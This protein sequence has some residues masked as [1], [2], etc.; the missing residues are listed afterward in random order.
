M[1]KR[2]PITDHKSRFSW[3]RLWLF[4]LDDTLHH[5][6][7]HIF[8]RQY[9]A[10]HRFIEQRFALTRDEA[11]VRRREL[12]LK[13]G[14][15][16]F[17]LHKEHGISLD[18]F[19]DYVQHD[20]ALEQLLDW[21]SADW[22]AVHRLPGR[23]VLLTNAQRSYTTRVLRHIGLAHLFDA[24]VC[25]NDMRFNG[26]FRPKPDTRMMRML[27]ASLRV[28]P[29]QAVLIEDTIGHLKAARSLKMKTALM[30]RYSQWA[31]GKGGKT[32]RAGRPSYV[33]AKIRSI[34]ELTRMP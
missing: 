14:T 30:T 24:V 33:Y 19:H 16:G 5:A 6:S 2:S 25:F 28:R 8:P 7:K 11:V 29:S 15:T 3:P 23:K 34:R 18:E 10:M 4:D 32:R 22:D 9:E 20:D 31:K 21:H 26:A 17:G 12:F 1:S 27:C 13:H